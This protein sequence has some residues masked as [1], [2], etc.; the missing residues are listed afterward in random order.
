MLSKHE[1]FGPPPASHP[2]ANFCS[3]IADCNLSHVGTQGAFF[4]WSK[5]GSSQQQTKFKLERALCTLDFMSFRSQ[6]NSNVLPRHCLDHSPLLLTCQQPSRVS[7][8]LFHFQSMWIL[9]P[10][11]K[12]FVEQ[13][14]QSST[15]S[16]NSM[17][18][19]SSKLGNLRVALLV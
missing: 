8:P 11:L 6:M 17:F 16:G 4:S 1:K 13:S 18:I 10:K 3:F 15:L 2:C 9:H 12:F 19:L 7:R 5:G 14:W